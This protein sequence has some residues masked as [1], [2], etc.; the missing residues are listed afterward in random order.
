MLDG[1]IAPVLIVLMVLL[2]SSRDLMGDYVNGLATKV[3]AWSAA[4]L[5]V[6]ADVAMIYQ[7]ASKGI[8]G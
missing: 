5:M 7:V 3:V 6:L 2:T 4:A 1:V 8:P